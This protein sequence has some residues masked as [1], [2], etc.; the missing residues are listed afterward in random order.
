ME[1]ITNYFKDF[2]G[3][4]ENPSKNPTIQQKAL[5]ETVQSAIAG[6][7]SGYLLSSNP[8]TRF[9]ITPLHGAIVG[10]MAPISIFVTRTLFELVRN[11][12]DSKFH[13]YL[14]SKIVKIA[15]Q[16]FICMSI[17][18]L[19]KIQYKILEISILYISIPVG[20]ILF[21]YVARINCKVVDILKRPT[22]TS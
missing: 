16:V 14:D 9:A 5:L 20:I 4:F 22:R 17:F 15:S 19:L 10:L 21:D 12:A 11:H 1:T 2:K 3:L 18:S 8:L 7:F 13:Q 6:V